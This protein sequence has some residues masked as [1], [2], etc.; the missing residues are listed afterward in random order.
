MEIIEL[1]FKEALD[2]I[3]ITLDQSVDQIV[4]AIKNLYARENG[5]RSPP[6][7]QTK[8]PD[9]TWKTELIIHREERTE[10]PIVEAKF[11]SRNPMEILVD[12]SVRVYDHEKKEMVEKATVIARRITKQRIGEIAGR[13]QTGHF[14]PPS[15]CGQKNKTA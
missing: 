15:S 13:N 1:Q 3:A 2:R 5:I 12:K 6:E 14:L 7:N 8:M 9:D 10:L 4:G 11:E